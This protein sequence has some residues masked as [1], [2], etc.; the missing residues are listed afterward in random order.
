MQRND[1]D[2]LKPEFEHY[3]SIREDLARENDERF[4]AIKNQRV[5]YIRDTYSEIAE[6]IYPEHKKGTVLVQKI[7]SNPD[8]HKVVVR[9]RITAPVNDETPTPQLYTTVSEQTPTVAFHL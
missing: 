5:L 8:A 2:V 9:P 3:L 4:V 7:S 1:V 6:L